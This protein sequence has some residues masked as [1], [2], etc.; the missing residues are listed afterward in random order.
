MGHF[1]KHKVA[2]GTLACLLGCSAPWK[3]VKL[4]FLMYF[5]TPQDLKQSRAN[6][7]QTTRT[8]LYAKGHSAHPGMLWRTHHTEPDPKSMEVVPL[9]LWGV[10]TRLDGHL[11]P[12]RYL[13]TGNSQPTLLAPPNRLYSDY[14]PK[15]S[16][17]LHATLK[18][19]CWFSRSRPLHA[20]PPF[21]STSLGWQYRSTLVGCWRELSAT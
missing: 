9:C 20:Y 19:H 21:L 18:P 4:P 2:V 10:L 12:C 8:T 14:S 7:D 17:S 11:V 1:L 5:F 6:T 15:R 16:V 3:P 13:Y